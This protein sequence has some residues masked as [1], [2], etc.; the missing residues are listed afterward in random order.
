MGVYFVAPTTPQATPGTPG[1]AKLISPGTFAR[2]QN[3]QHLPTRWVA[4]SGLHR[5]IEG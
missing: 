5:G 3:Y 2:G 1:A 4:F